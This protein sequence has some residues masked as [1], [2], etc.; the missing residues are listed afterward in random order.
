MRLI[1]LDRLPCTALLILLHAH[2]FVVATSSLFNLPSSVLIASA[3]VT[4]S[5]LNSAV[6]AYSLGR[7][8]DVTVGVDVMLTTANSS[9][10][11]QFWST[12]APQVN[13][14]V[15]T[16]NDLDAKASFLAGAADVAFFT[17][18]LTADDLLSHAD[19]AQYPMLA[20]AVVACYNLPGITPGFTLTI[21]AGNLVAI[22]GGIITS[23]ND[24]LLAVDNPNVTLPAQPIVVISTITPSGS[25]SAPTR[26]LTLPH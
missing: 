25:V 23:W 11:Y 20:N 14:T 6:L 4:S 16:G 2:F 21:S 3:D 18:P 24:P 17:G 19:V 22:Y 7:R 15:Q 10:L 26:C 8:Y 9:F 5:L 12:V 1:W 13:F